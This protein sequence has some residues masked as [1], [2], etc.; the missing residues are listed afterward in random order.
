MIKKRN[1]LITGSSRGIG[2]FIAK[3]L[4]QDNNNLIFIN[5]RNKKDLI[6]LK[7]KL[8]K[9]EIVQGNINNS[10]ILKRINQ[11]ISKLDVLICN[12]GSGK[13]VSTGKETK[14]DWEKSLN[15]NFYSAVNAIKVFEKKLIKSKGIIICISSICGME[16]IQGA[17]ITY[18]VSKAALNAF[19]R[20]HSKYLGA[21]GV[22][23]NAIA[24]GNILFKGSTWEKKLRKNK[25]KVLKQISQEVSL[26]KFGSA[27]DVADLVNY[28]IKDSSKFINGSIIVAD[29]GQ[30]RG[31]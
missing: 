9:C 4:H 7:K 2:C 18:S 28:L 3:K 5:G 6:N 25:R 17:P 16:F 30:I 14:K 11:K 23:L 19:V 15:Q 24:P 1:I 20:F 27:E 8:T 29:G 12:I 13:S 10:K 21:K 22:R 26:K 31:I